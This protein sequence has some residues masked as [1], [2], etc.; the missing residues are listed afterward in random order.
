MDGITATNAP[1]IVGLI[2]I[3]L[4]LTR[5][6][7]TLITRQLSKRNGTSMTPGKPGGY[8][9]LTPEEHNALIRLDEAHA[10]YDS[11]GT[12]LWYVPRSWAETQHKITAT[13]EKM[14]DILNTIAGTQKAIV[15]T[16]DRMDDA[17]RRIDIPP[18]RG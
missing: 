14:T 5:L 13:L 16:L 11:D 1:I 9:G 3:A 17:S 8:S 18:R 10:K 4:I 2:M 6:V 12:P 7:E 15:R